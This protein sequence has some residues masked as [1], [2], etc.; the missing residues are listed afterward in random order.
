MFQ[1]GLMIGTWVGLARMPAQ[2]KHSREY[3]TLMLGRR[4]RITEIWRHFLAFAESLMQMLRAGR[5]Q[6]VR[7]ELK[8][9][10]GDEFVRLS[11]SNRPALFGTFHFGASDLLGYLLSDFGRNISIVRLRVGNSDDTRLLGERFSQRVRFLWVNDPQ[12][13]LFELKDALLQGLSLAMKCDRV[14]FSAR[15]EPFEFLGARRLFP[16]TIYHLAVIFDRPVVFCH[17]LPTADPE[18]IDVYASRVFEPATG[19][20]REENLQRARMHY[21]AVLA[22]LETL[23]RAHPLQWFNFIPMNPVVAQP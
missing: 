3:L 4:P 18:R 15:P 17:A 21:Q 19:V 10:H 13:L 12:A 9:P 1:L 8:G 20:S 6:A 22:D 14:E 2:R 11:R 23:V 5:G 16:F 7:C